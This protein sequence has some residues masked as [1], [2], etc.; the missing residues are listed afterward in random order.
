MAKCRICGISAVFL[1]EGCEKVSYCG[2]KCQR[3]H[4]KRSHS[5]KCLAIGNKIEQT[6]KDDLP[7]PSVLKWYFKVTQLET[8]NKYTQKN[9]AS[10]LETHESYVSYWF[11]GKHTP[12]SFQS[13]LKEWWRNT[14]S[15]YPKR[16]MN[17]E[18]AVALLGNKPMLEQSR[19]EGTSSKL[20]VVIVKKEKEKEEKPE[21]VKLKRD[22]TLSLKTTQELTTTKL[23]KTES[24]TLE[25]D[26][27]YVDAVSIIE[28]RK[29]LWNIVEF[30]PLPTGDKELRPGEIYVLFDYTKKGRCK[31]GRARDSD[32]RLS[33]MITGNNDLTR[34]Y[35]IGVKN[36]AWVEKVVHSLL[37]KY[38]MRFGKDRL[39]NKGV[40]QPKEWFAVHHTLGICT[41]NY[42]VDKFDQIYSL[43]H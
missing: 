22:K 41:V 30:P 9:L 3:R 32:S 8:G 42:V 26:D 35:S 28:P 18:E 37:K 11:N 34:V 27:S 4:W 31:I 36:D 14:K 39:V 38:Q 29:D 40:T 5:R 16:P 17:E 20:K 19:S 33:S 1:C 2:T 25:S 7:G 24:I 43:E 12:D 23:E 15:K 13:K 6:G 21:I 10:D